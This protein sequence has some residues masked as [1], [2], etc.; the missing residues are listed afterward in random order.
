MLHGPF[1]ITRDPR[2]GFDSNV[3]SSLVYDRELGVAAHTLIHS[4]KL[5][6]KALAVTFWIVQFGFESALSPAEA[7]CMIIDD[8]HRVELTC[9]NVCLAHIECL[10]VN[11]GE[12]DV[13]N[14]DD[15][16]R[17]E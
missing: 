15:A 1:E 4:F 17:L 9:V 8:V 3:H 5:K 14:E 6:A 16:N 13:R 10:I 12:E 2:S 11:Q 7:E